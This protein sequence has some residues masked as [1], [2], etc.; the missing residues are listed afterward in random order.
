MTHFKTLAIL[1]FTLLTAISS[2][3][4][5]SKETLDNLR[6][7]FINRM[8]P[9]LVKDQSQDLNMS[10]N[11]VRGSI[12]VSEP[13]LYKLEHNLNPLEYIQ[14][15]FT[16]NEFCYRVKFNVKHGEATFK[17]ETFIIVQ[18]SDEATGMNYEHIYDVNNKNIRMHL[19]YGCW[20]LSE[21]TEPS[22][23]LKV[24]Q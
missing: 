10:L 4:A 12:A 7:D 1:A 14:S 18:S 20:G 3:Q 21:T 5:Q 15:L 6:N 16:G 23:S 11:L 24:V 22:L 2:A 9:Q 19:S 17:T 8:L 13:T